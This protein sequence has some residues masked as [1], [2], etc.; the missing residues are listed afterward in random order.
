MKI[1]L[2]KDTRPI[3]LF[4]S[5]KKRPHHLVSM[6]RARP[7]AAGTARWGRERRVFALSTAVHA[8]GKVA[9]FE[10]SPTNLY[11]QGPRHSPK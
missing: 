10:V 5:R 3:D 7:M 1:Y 8:R 4:Y 6:H 11:A 2:P 9:S